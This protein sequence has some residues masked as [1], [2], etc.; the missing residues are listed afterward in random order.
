MRKPRRH[1]PFQSEKVREKVGNLVA[2][3]TSPIKPQ[4]RLS[5]HR[6]RV[7]VPSSPAIPSKALALIL[8]KPSRTQKGTFLCPFLCPFSPGRFPSSMVLTLQR[9]P[10]QTVVTLRS[11]RRKTPTTRLLPELHIWRA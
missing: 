11:L 6:S 10:I 9:Y 2:T 3:T 8:A 4:F 5:R 7:R 1:H